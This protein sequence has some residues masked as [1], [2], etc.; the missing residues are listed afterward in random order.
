MVC[1]P[2]VCDRFHVAGWIF[3]CGNQAVAGI[4]ILKTTQIREIKPI[5]PNT[6]VRMNESTRTAFKL[7]GG[8]GGVFILP[9]NVS[10]P[11]LGA[12]K[13]FPN[14]G[15]QKQLFSKPR[16]SKIKNTSQSMIC[17]LK[18]QEKQQLTAL[19]RARGAVCGL[20]HAGPSHRGPTEEWKCPQKH[21]G[22]QTH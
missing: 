7:S 11:Q 10:F 1:S 9:G 19:L 5:F 14:W 18:W 17:S 21:S 22:R 4:T 8:G 20:W 13:H 12:Q 6:P 2:S 16:L 15:P 3:Y